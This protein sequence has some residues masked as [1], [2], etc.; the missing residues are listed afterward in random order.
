MNLFK[1]Y[2]TIYFK[3]GNKYIR[4]NTLIRLKTRNIILLSQK[5][6]DKIICS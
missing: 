5:D 4:V 6:D 2:Q 3:M 1:K